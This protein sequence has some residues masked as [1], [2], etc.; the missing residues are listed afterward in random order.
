M[1]LE[2]KPANVR[3]SAPAIKGCLEREVLFKVFNSKGIFFS[4]YENDFLDRT[5]YACYHAIEEYPTKLLG[6]KNAPKR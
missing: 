3:K 6:I 1:I 5:I 2:I 4:I